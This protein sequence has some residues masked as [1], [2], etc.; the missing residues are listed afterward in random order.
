MLRA[1]IAIN[2]LR[3][4][5]SFS[6]WF[7][8]TAARVGFADR[9]FG[10]IRVGNFRIDGVWLVASTCVVFLAMFY[11]FLESKSDPEARTDAYLCLAWV[12]AFAI[13]VA[14]AFLTGVIDFG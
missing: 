10:A 1:V 6:P 2:F 14:R 11:F 3:F 8:G 13:F 4:A 9:L 7:E 12:V 5:L